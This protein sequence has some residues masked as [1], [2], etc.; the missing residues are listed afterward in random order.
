MLDDCRYRA[1]TQRLGLLPMPQLMQ[2]RAPRRPGMPVD[3][4][5]CSELRTGRLPRGYAQDPDTRTRRHHWIVGD[6]RAV[7]AITPL[8]RNHLLVFPRAH[9]TASSL[10]GVA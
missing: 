10:L 8:R 5:L 6:A 4:E 7:A 1:T 2:V 3:C 9:A